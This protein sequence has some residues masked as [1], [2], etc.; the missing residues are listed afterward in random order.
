MAAEDDWTELDFVTGDDGD[1]DETDGA[2]ANNES[3]DE[4][5][6]TQSVQTGIHR[7]RPVEDALLAWLG[8]IGLSRYAGAL[9]ELGVACLA[10]CAF[11]ELEDLVGGADG[12]GGGIG[13]NI[14]QARK[15]LRLRDA[16]DGTAAAKT[17]AQTTP[18]TNG[19]TTVTETLA[20][21]QTAAAA[22][23]SAAPP[24]AT[25]EKRP[26]NGLERTA[27]KGLRHSGP[28]LKKGYLPEGRPFTEKQL[29]R[30][31]NRRFDPDRQEWVKRDEPLSDEELECWNDQARWLVCPITGKEWI[32]A[33]TIL[34]VGI[35]HA[36]RSVDDEE[37]QRMF[38]W[39]KANALFNKAERGYKAE[40]I[41]N[42]GD[43]WW[44]TFYVY[45]NVDP[46]D[47]D[48][49]RPGEEALAA[50]GSDGANED[51]AAAREDN[52]AE[53]A[54]NMGLVEV[55][56]GPAFDVSAY[57]LG[58]HG[59]TVELKGVPTTVKS[60]FDRGV[61]HNDAQW[62]AMN[63]Q[64]WISRDGGDNYIPK[65]CTNRLSFY[66]EDF[67][68]QR[69][70][71]KN[72]RSQLS[73]LLWRD[74][75]RL[76]RKGGE[77]DE[78]RLAVA[79]RKVLPRILLAAIM[80]IFRGRSMAKNNKRCSEEYVEYAIR[81]YLLIHQ[82]SIKLVVYFRK[83][84]DI[85]VAS[86]LR[87]I[88]APFSG[89]AQREWPHDGN[90]LLEFLI[91]ASI[92]GVPW[93]LVREPFVR[94]LFTQLVRSMPKMKWDS[95]DRS[96]LM[97]SLFEKNKNYL[98]RVLFVHSFF[99][100]G[101][102]VG[103]LD[104]LYGRCAGTLPRRER[105]AMKARAAAVTKHAGS[106]EDVWVCLGMGAGGADKFEAQEHAYSLLMFCSKAEKGKAGSRGYG[107]RLADLPIPKRYSRDEER[108]ALSAR[109]LR[110][111]GEVID[112]SAGCSDTAA[113]AARTLTA[114]RAKHIGYPK[115][116]PSGNLDRLRCN[117]EGCGRRFKCRDHL[118]KHLKHMCGDAR[119]VEGYHRS[120]FKL[121]LRGLALS[122]LNGTA[123]PACGEVFG[124]NSMFRAHLSDIAGYKFEGESTLST[125]H[126]R[127]D[128]D[129]ARGGI[130][131]L[132]L[133]NYYSDPSCCAICKAT[134]CLSEEKVVDKLPPREVMLVPCGHLYACRS[135]GPRQ[136]QCIV[137]DQLS[138]SVLHV[139]HMDAPERAKKETTAGTACCV[140]CLVN[141]VSHIIIP[142]GHPCLCDG[143]APLIGASGLC[144]I[145][146]CPI[147][148]I[149]KIFGN[150][151]Y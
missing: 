29:H 77:T 1:D 64:Y 6:P 54:V 91:G 22:S 60:K 100:A 68:G 99:S 79:V 130:S 71:P 50:S 32:D 149:V 133:E 145:G 45:P 89:K 139:A 19:E 39:E 18:A 117:Y 112:N 97:R 59:G 108:L 48:F 49:H 98:E 42:D 118:F 107:W 116:N 121:K 2:G 20:P 140:V 43:P 123:C 4:P 95:K 114:E 70:F 105:E 129:F 30:I 58:I 142:C 57:N 150:V 23:S 66:V 13:M 81:T 136:A 137:C 144:P 78:T 143:C 128:N 5:T 103:E 109:L 75:D 61:R 55:M 35:Y 3:D 148:C 126:E 131:T 44:S 90:G 9:S 65:R 135:C 120:H 132:A 10:D 67:H 113:E 87:W 62:N 17:A 92:V 33:A 27:A 125:E 127:P 41:G 141:P 134:A 111:F 88:M 31:R 21:L 11:I 53:E 15:F 86:I 83:T 146:R 14:I 74:R 93:R 36:P 101:R 151:S 110:F 16:P 73:L 147:E 102:P 34:G 82:V 72:I 38:D 104:R 84:R 119:M 37:R 85:L 63:F 138:T 69:V 46:P 12:G 115:L 47:R 25:A 80:E 28:V 106:L 96:R 7:E 51:G 52:D 76:T 40:G 94:A 122:D 8:R 124:T 56:I 24:P 26:S